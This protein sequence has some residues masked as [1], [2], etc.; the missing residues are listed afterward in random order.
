MIHKD[1]LGLRF[2]FSDN[3]LTLKENGYFYLYYL[4]HLINRNINHE[5][6]D[7]YTSHNKQT[8]HASIST[9]TISSRYT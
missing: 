2:R 8:K 5:I 6:I 9:V 7:V 4:Y 3:I 1:C